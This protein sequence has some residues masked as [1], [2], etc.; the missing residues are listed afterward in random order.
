MKANSFHIEPDR[1]VGVRASAT[2][3]LS[4]ELNVFAEDPLDAVRHAGGWMCDRVRAGWKVA[5]VLPSGTGRDI[6][7][8]ALD[9]LGV[10][11]RSADAEFDDLVQ[12]PALAVS[13]RLLGSEPRLRRAVRHALERGATEV[14]L[15]GDAGG[16]TTDLRVT[17]VRY[18]M[19]PAARAFKA[20]A[21][22]AASGVAEPGAAEHFHS[23]A[24]WYPL[25]GPDLISVR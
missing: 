6:D 18:P 25:D 11:T 5:V 23:C 10:R 14:T 4:Y 8:R 12:A 1:A 24:P 21:M 20:Q 9:I 22:L 16:R 15:W 17:D 19:T 3:L 13:A 2:A 7:T